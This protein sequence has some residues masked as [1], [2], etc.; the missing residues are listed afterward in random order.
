MQY[1]TIS[2]VKYAQNRGY[3]L[4]ELMLAMAVGSIIMAAMYTSYMIVAHQ[5]SR[6]SAI[7]GV[8]ERGIPTLRLLERDIR[9]AGFKAVDGN[10]DSDFGTITTPITITD[11]GSACCDQI[12]VIYDKDIAT[13]YRIT[14]YTAARTNPARDALYMNRDTWDDAGAVWVADIS[15]GLVTDYVV[16]FQVEGSDPNA[17]GNPQIIDISMILR[18]KEQLKDAISYTKPSYDIGNYSFTTNDN[19]YRDEFNAT[20]NIRNLR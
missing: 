19:F 6:V 13:R 14:Y 15:A 20:I 10:M 9:M 7:A 3:S 5:Q 12:Q 11:S 1:N 8:Q 2:S 17:D 18:S 4:I 16:D